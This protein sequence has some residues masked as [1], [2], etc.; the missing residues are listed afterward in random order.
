[1]LEWKCD[2]TDRTVR[3]S[4]LSGEWMVDFEVK[5]VIEDG[6]YCGFHISD[7]RMIT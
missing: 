5:R 2:F 4:D 3:W 1:M 6:E 7:H